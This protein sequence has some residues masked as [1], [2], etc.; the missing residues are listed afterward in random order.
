VPDVAREDKIGPSVAHSPIF[1]P[2]KKPRRPERVTDERLVSYMQSYLMR[3]RRYRGR[4]GLSQLATALA[5][6]R[7]YTIA[8]VSLPVLSILSTPTTDRGRR[9]R[10]KLEANFADAEDELEDELGRLPDFAEIGARV[11]TCYRAKSRLSETATAQVRELRRA[12]ARHEYVHLGAAK[13]L[14]HTTGLVPPKSSAEAFNR[15]LAT[16]HAS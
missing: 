2:E 14:P 15:Y 11:A 7:E 5:I 8:G 3:E 1:Q 9:D 12:A 10:I 6:F 4:R 13:W 16:F